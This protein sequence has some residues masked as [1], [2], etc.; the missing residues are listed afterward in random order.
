[1]LIAG[2]QNLSKAVQ[3]TKQHSINQHHAS[4]I[5]CIHD[6]MRRR[7]VTQTAASDLQHSAAQSL[8]DAQPDI[9]LEQHRVGA[10]LPELVLADDTAKML[11]ASKATAPLV[12]TTFSDRSSASPTSRAESPPET[13]QSTTAQLLMR[14]QDD[15]V[16]TSPTNFGSGTC[17]VSSGS[18]GNSNSEEQQGGMVPY[19]LFAID[20]TWQEAKEIF[21]VLPYSHCQPCPVIQPVSMSGMR[22]GFLACLTSHS[23]LS[24]ACDFAFTTPVLSAMPA[25]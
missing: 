16:Q 17:N 6:H 20:G 15:L 23:V 7:F 19:V 14:R 8:L 4:C 9:L 18:H 22:G 13:S 3:Q 12:C 11:P 24:V 21:K 25:K 1:M 2:S 5:S 10:A